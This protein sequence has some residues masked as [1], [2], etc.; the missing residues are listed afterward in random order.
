MSAAEEH[1]AYEAGFVDGLARRPML[2]VVDPDARFTIADLVAAFEQGRALERESQSP[3]GYRR[4]YLD[5]MAAR[6]IDQEAVEL[7]GRISRRLAGGELSPPAP[8]A[9]HLRVVN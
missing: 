2:A 6:P 9:R 7:A 4:G 5:A 1:G 3:G 8:R